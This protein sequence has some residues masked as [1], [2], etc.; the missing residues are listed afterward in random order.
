MIEDQRIPIN[1]HRTLMIRDRPP[2]TI[3]DPTLTIE[4]SST[5]DRAIPTVEDLIDQD[6]RLQSG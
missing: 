5:A 3:T 4:D 2:P 6:H 1:G